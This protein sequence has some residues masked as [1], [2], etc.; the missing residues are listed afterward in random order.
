M[1]ATLSASG[2]HLAYPSV[3]V[4][5]GIDLTIEEGQAP[6]GL[7]GPSGVG[8]T[9]LIEILAGVAT[10]DQGRVTFDGHDVSRKRGARA[11]EFRASVRFV[12]QYSLTVVDSHETVGSRLR[13]AVRVARKAGRTHRVPPVDLLAAAGLPGEFLRRRMITLSGGERQRVAL[14]TALATR[15]K[16]LILDEPLTAVDQGA[17]IRLARALRSTI[18]QLGIG[19]LV[20][21]HDL[22]LIN[23]LCP[24]VAFLNDGQL[25]ERGELRQMFATSEHPAIQDLAKYADLV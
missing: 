9:S 17:R 10:P 2:I 22:R 11:K 21:S 12:S 23:L 19:A 6:L 8:K 14:A 16:I 13:E 20:A 3:E 1:P 4:L 25:V 5:S 15:P 24:E 7:V 18:A